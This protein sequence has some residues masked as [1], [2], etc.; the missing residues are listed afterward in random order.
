M[1]PVMFGTSDRSV[2]GLYSPAAAPR[3][4]RGVVICP[5]FGQ[6]YMRSHRTCRIL[7]S[8]LARTGHDVLRLDYFGTGNSHGESKDLSVSGAIDDVITAAQEISDIAAVRRVTLVGLRI[9]A[10]IAAFAA[11]RVGT[12]DKLVLWDPVADGSRYLADEVRVPGRAISLADEP[13]AAV[14]FQGY[15]LTSALQVELAQL[16]MFGL[17]RFPGKV[18]I[19]VSAASDQHRDLA[20]HV[21][22]RSEALDFEVLENEPSWKELGNVGVGAVPVD[23]LTRIS[24]W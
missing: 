15:V 7:A 23:I 3:L 10:A 22:S 2:L 14:E 13:V 6:E 5:P 19:I 1:M 8:R 4:A 20:S 21:R 12:V 11:A 24:Q 18:L 9:G 17:A 16:S